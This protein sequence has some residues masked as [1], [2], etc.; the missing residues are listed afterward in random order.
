VVFIEDLTPILVE[1]FTPS[2]FFFNKK[3]KVV[4][5]REMHQKEGAAVKRHRVIIYGEALEEV[6]F[7]EEV[8]GSLG[9]FA[10]TN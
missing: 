4:V 3:R 6:Y 7:V 5:K 10:R 9:N 1:E 8:A 2:N